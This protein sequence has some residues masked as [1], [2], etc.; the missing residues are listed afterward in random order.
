MNAF[1]LDADH[2]AISE[3][4]RAF[5]DDKLAPRAL[6]WDEK[7]HFPVDVIREAAALDTAAI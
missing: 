1:S 5:A 2:I 7:K 4:A 3:M 6:E